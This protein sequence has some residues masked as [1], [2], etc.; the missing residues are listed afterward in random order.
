MFA[1]IQTLTNEFNRTL[2]QAKLVD[3]KK[4]VK[5]TTGPNITEFTKEVHFIMQR[6]YTN[7]D[8]LKQCQETLQHI[9]KVVKHREEIKHIDLYGYSNSCVTKNFA[10][11]W[12]YEKND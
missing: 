5:K 4:R 11:V 1:I 12:S 6:H 3:F 10:T 7:V 2:D 8:M 9:E